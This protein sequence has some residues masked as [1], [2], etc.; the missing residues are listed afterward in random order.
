MKI[1]QDV[2]R[3]AAEQG[4]DETAALELGMQQKSAEFAEGGGRVY[5]PVVD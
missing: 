2:R 1:S 5:L 3:Y 4:V